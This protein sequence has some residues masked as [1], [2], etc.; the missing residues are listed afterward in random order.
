[1]PG[2]DAREAAAIVFG[3]LP[4][5]AHLPELPDRGAGADP[6][7]RT[8]A[9]LV[10]LAVDLVPSGYRI[11]ARPGRTHRHAVD[12]LRW[13]LDAVTEAAGGTAPTLVKTQVAGPW[14]L[15]A[16]I[17]LA[18]GHRVLTDHGA[19]RDLTESLTEGLAAHVADVAERTGARVLVQFDEPALPDVLAGSLSTPS[20]YGTVDSVPEPR[21]RELLSAVFASARES[22][23]TPVVAHSCARRPPI[24]L[25]HRAGAD[26]VSLDATLL[27]GAPAVLL[28]E[29][30]QAWDEGVTLLL[31]LVATQPPPTT[32]PPPGAREL[33]KPA[34]DLADR[35]GFR[36]S[37][38]AERAVPTPTCGL[39][40][41]TA[42]WA[43]RA[44]TLATDLGTVFSDPS[45]S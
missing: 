15:A 6:I 19:L 10:D 25:L 23:G 34:F 24:G 17:E 45:E 1:M 42:G 5:F 4:G 27:D 38:L 28:D 8:A 39:A 21:A 40:G 32:A 7:G 16:A 13:D 11:A 26:A 41:T 44:L 14:T 2:T 29:I 12:L 43:R 36:R 30:G 37:I 31:G 9:M 20:G 3:E 22:T 35:L 33:A 18:R